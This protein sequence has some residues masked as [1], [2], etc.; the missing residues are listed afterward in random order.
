MDGEVESGAIGAVDTANAG[1]STSV[2]D[3]W[4]ASFDGETQGWLENKGWTA[5]DGLTQMVRAHRSLES[6]MGRDKVVWPKDA[7]DKQAWAEIHRRMGVPSSWEDYGLAPLGPDGKPDT[8][9]DRSYADGM[10]QVFHKLGIGKETAAALATEHATL[11]AA[12]TAADNEAFQR[13]SAQDFDALRREWGGE[14]DTRLAAAQRASRAFG[15]EPATMGKIERAIGTRAM[16]SLLSEIGTAISEDR[17]TGT[18]GFGAGGWLTPEAANARLV[19]LRGDKDWTR[20]YFA[21]D[22]SA[23]AEYDRLISAVANRG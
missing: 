11:Q 2:A 19:E 8:M 1:E 16:V 22:K 13:S 9:A 5:E 23:I 17:G 21:G 12:L 15:L 7:Q 4:F 20:R 3:S 10:A 18:G 6:M 14:A